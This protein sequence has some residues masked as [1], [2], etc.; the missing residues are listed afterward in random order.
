M[1]KAT[2]LKRFQ[3]VYDPEH[4]VSILDLKIV[5]ED[6][7]SINDN[8]VSVTFTPTTPFCP[9]GAVIGVVIKKVLQD[10]DPEANVEVKVKAGSHVREPMVNQMINDP[11]QY[12]RTIKNLEDN[13]LL[14]Q[15]IGPAM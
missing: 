15:C 2:I 4:P 9:M 6:D 12:E 14:D 13:G 11:A 1:D 7:V 10:M 8:N 3:T 5:T